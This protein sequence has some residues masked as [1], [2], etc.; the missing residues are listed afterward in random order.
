M[1]SAICLAKL[2]RHLPTKLTPNPTTERVVDKKETMAGVTEDNVTVLEHHPAKRY[3][4]PSSKT[5]PCLDDLDAL[6]LV[7]EKSA[8][9]THASIDTTH[10]PPTTKDRKAKDRKAF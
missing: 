5:Y 2:R 6:L 10:C 9:T 7:Q 3:S 4:S 8:R 1:I